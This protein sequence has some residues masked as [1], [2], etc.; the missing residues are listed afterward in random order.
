VRTHLGQV[1]EAPTAAAVITHYPF[2]KKDGL[3]YPTRAPRGETPTQNRPPR[4]EDA[5]W[6]LD[7]FLDERFP[8]GGT[9]RTISKNIKPD[10][11]EDHQAFL[12]FLQ[13][14]QYSGHPCAPALLAAL[15]RGEMAIYSKSLPPLRSCRHEKFHWWF[16]A[17]SQTNE[18]QYHLGPPGSALPP[19]LPSPKASKSPGQN[20]Q[21]KIYDKKRK[22]EGVIGSDTSTTTR[23]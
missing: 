18:T 8:N 2:Q 1:F 4:Q 23:V 14:S 6:L 22:A 12:A 10:S 7:T 20:N 19:V 3:R 17:R 16:S 9:F 21:T 11:T 5:L 13:R 15:S